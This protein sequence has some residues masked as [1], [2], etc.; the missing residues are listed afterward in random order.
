[1]REPAAEGPTE[2]ATR[3]RAW[4]A[5]NLWMPG[6]MRWRRV[7]RERAELAAIIALALDEIT[8]WDREARLVRASNQVAHSSRISIGA[9][10]AEYLAPRDLQ[11]TE[12]T[13]LGID[14]HP[15]TKALQGQSV[16][17]T[18]VRETD[19][20]GATRYLLLQVATLRETGAG[21]TGAVL[22]ARDIT[23]AKQRQGQQAEVRAAEQ[24]VQVATIAERDVLQQI[25]DVLPEGVIIYDAS[26]H[27][28]SVNHIAEAL[29]GINV[30]G[31]KLA[32]FDLTARRLDGTPVPWND[33]ASVLAGP[34]SASS[35]GVQLVVRNVATGADI[36][37]LI[38]SV[39]LQD[40][41]GTITGGV[42]VF[43]DISAIR[44]LEEQRDRMLTKV[45]HDLR[46]PL[47]SITGMSQILQLRV[48]QVDEPVRDRFEHCLK[49][50]ETASQR[51]AAQISELLDYTQVQ[52]GRPVGLDLESTDVVALVRQMLDEHQH[53]TE[54][55]TLELHAAEEVMVVMVDARRLERAI[56]NLL[57]NAI[58][59]S[60]QGGLI[61]VSVGREAG[62]DGH[63]LSI[64]VA[65]S[66]LGIPKNDLP[67]MFEQYYRASNVATTIP[68]TGI[69]L[70]NVRHMIDRHG[71]TVSIDSTE[72][73]GTTVT[74]RLPLLRAGDKRL[75][76]V[77]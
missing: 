42:S 45:T 15:V 3:L 24:E 18:E 8:I 57:V 38:S 6:N 40:V 23:D 75:G 58:K 64:T 68:G 19:G 51:M 16:P 20:Q 56:A 77:R 26:A 17:P 25:L 9:R 49:I 73:A 36:P 29:L 39:A 50:I 41:D 48:G 61:V 10:L 72:G 27:V 32:D 65:D 7:A 76:E 44:N 54:R 12:G 71:G 62:R 21:P 70:A 1:M 5:A 35:Q 60:P 2:R 67:H 22:I 46:N 55:H 34:S 11:R 52:T 74:V 4:I 59:Y 33:V 28:T 37:I 69:G 13:R 43:Q 66:G 14:D 30:L 31:R 47:T 63:W 53:A